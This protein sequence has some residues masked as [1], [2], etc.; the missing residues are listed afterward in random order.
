MTFTEEDKHLIK[1]LREEKRYSAKKFLREFPNKN[2]TLGGLNYF[3]SKLDRYRSIRRC[4]GSGRPRTVTT[5]ANVDNVADMV[6][7]QEDRP[8]THHSVRQIARNLSISRSSVHSIIKE[9]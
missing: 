2:W 3:I 4:T 7:S 6:Q 8:N 1:V 5:P 9:I